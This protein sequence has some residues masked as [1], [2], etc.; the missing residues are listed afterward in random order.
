[1]FDLLG[2]TMKDRSKTKKELL[3]ELER[4]RQRIA[5]FEALSAGDI[6]ASGPLDKIQNRFEKQAEALTAELLHSSERLGASTADF[7]R[8]DELLGSRGGLYRALVET[9]R[10]VIW[11]VDLDLNYAYVSPSVTEALG[12]TVGEIMSMNPLDGLTS[13][14][15]ERV[16]KAYREELTQE[17]SEAGTPYK[18][19]TEEIERYRKDGAI[20]WEEVTATFLRNNDGKPIG[21]IGI[22]RDIS[23][24]KLLENQLGQIRDEL[25]KR[26]EERTAELEQ[27]NA[28]LRDQIFQCNKAKHA[29]GEAM[30]KFRTLVEQ[31]PAIT[32]IAALDDTSTTLYI[33]PQAE[34]F[35]GLSP[36]YYQADSDIWR[37]RLHPEDRDRVL[38]ELARTRSTGE[39][40]SSEYRMIAT[41]N[42]TL[43]FRDD[44]V[45]VRGE[46]G[47]PLCLQGVMLDITD[48][49]KT[50]K[51][52]R[53]S[54][55]RFRTVFEAA[56][57]CVFIKNQDLRYTAVNPAMIDLLEVPANAIIEHTFDDVHGPDGGRDIQNEDLR[58]L[59]G[60]TVETEFSL[61]VGSREI[62]LSCKK[63][64]LRD[65]YGRISGLCGIAR[66]ITDRKRKTRGFEGDGSHYQS[67]VVV[68]TLKHVEN[69]AKTDSNVLLLG[70]SGSGKDYLAN[71]LHRLSRRSGGPIFTINCAAVP[72]EL[73]E[74][75]LF[76][77]EAGA[78]TG[79]AG[80]KR[81]LLE[82]ADGGTLLLN[83]IGDLSPQLQAKILTFLDT[84][85]FTRL[86]GEKTVLVNTRIIAATNRYLEKDVEAGKFRKD[87][88]FRL[89]VFVIKIPPLRERI[90][91]LPLLVSELVDSLQKKMG[92]REVRLIDPSVFQVFSS[93]DWPGNVRELRNVLERAL[94]VGNGDRIRVADIGDLPEKA[95]LTDKGYGALFPVHLNVRGAL[96]KTV[97][98][99]KRTL[100]MEA[101]QRSKGSIKKAALIL[102]ISRDSLAYLMK[103][104]QIPRR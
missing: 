30:A 70:E 52:L 15:R 59:Q 100:V 9:S 36:D 7:T 83:E 51:A 10:D 80:R 98:E 55:E 4:L 62:T 21:I 72:P 61:Q 81:G 79:A 33:S 12:Y 14:S 20:L 16:L 68:D 87:L 5:Q 69:V 28:T 2:G 31:I 24:R 1:M 53:E 18:S 74:S 73:A 78:F 86:G 26:V 63:V 6:K 60:H 102:G 49:K 94:I 48:A 99:A 57:D 32:Y 47:Q 54:E 25:E 46:S 43:W 104:L 41:D 95:L 27:L 82:L 34:T 45:L 84:Q 103:T 64:P 3:E 29:L 101:L 89:N 88:Y 44:A 13:P 40:F 22:S 39:R 77:H 8:I 19:R 17:T 23:E 37:K 93:Y 71:Y 38:A 97:S 65:S 67:K 90:E 75:E 66:D 50:E 56:Q 96:P 58:V 11:I 35:L 85:S 91:D 42:R 76:G 92:L